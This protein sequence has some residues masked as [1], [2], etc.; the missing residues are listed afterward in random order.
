MFAF[1]AR[2]IVTNNPMSEIDMDF[3]LKIK[4]KLNCQM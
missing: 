3:I 2:K 4:E 1:I